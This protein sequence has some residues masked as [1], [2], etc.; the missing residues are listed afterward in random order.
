MEEKKL[1][2]GIFPV[3]Y[4]AAFK[5]KVLGLRKKKIKLHNK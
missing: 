2:D 1:K 5:M 3:K 4:K